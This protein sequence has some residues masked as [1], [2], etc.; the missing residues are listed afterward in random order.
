VRLQFGISK[1]EF[2][3]VVAV[4]AVSSATLL[5]RMPHIQAESERLE[6]EQTV[7]NI[8]VGVQHV[9]GEHIINGQEYRIAEVA[10]FNPIE[11]L[12]HEPTGYDPKRTRPEQ[13]GEWAYDRESRELAY[14]PKF[15]AEFS[16]VQELRW[17]WS[18]VVDAVGHP[19]AI[20]LVAIN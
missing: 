9:I 15:P 14:R 1:H 8:R 11:L 10:N 17:S 6:V 2:A 4:V 5:L 13:A 20:H 7:R 16:G 18:P 12:E 3:I 19:V